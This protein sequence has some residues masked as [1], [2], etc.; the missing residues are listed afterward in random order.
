MFQSEQKHRD[1]KRQHTH[2]SS[3]NSQGQLIKVETIQNR[4]RDMQNELEHDWGLCMPTKLEKARHIK[5][6]QDNSD[7][8]KP[9]V[10]H[11]IAE[12]QKNPLY[13]HA[14]QAE[15]HGDPAVEVRH[16][17]NLIHCKPITPL[18]D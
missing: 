12:N 7:T 3:R 18:S 13:L 15:H 8:L 4:L 2:V 17:H 16:K 9:E 1:P 5:R 10:H 6:W 11:H 14:W